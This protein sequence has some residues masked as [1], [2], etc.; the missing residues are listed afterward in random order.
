MKEDKDKDDPDDKNDKE[1]EKILWK[2][3]GVEKIISEM[4]SLTNI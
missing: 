3:A 2:S 1:V 4:H